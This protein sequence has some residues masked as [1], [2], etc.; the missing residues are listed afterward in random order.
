MS[1]DKIGQLDTYGLNL[2]EQADRKYDKDGK[3]SGSIFEAVL[4]ASSKMYSETNALQQTV[5]AKQLDF[6]TGKTDNILDVMMAQEKALTSLNF[7][8][9]VTNKVIEAYKEIMQVQL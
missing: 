2:V 8:V 9:Q 6:A 7:T 4:D 1:I 3:T 5:E